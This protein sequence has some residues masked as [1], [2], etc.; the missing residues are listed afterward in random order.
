MKHRK[1]GAIITKSVNESFVAIREKLV[2][3]VAILE[4]GCGER[5]LVNGSFS[6]RRRR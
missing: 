5:A 3:V 2:K 1:A 6:R 4:P